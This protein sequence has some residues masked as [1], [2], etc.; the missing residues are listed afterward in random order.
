MVVWEHPVRSWD[1]AS[2]R[3]QRERDV[4]PA[5]PL[6]LGFEGIHIFDITDPT[7]PVVKKQFAWLRRVTSAGAPASAGRPH[8]DRRAGRRARRPLPLHRRLERHL[9]RHRHRPHQALAD[10]TDAKFLSRAAHGRAGVLPRQQL[11]AQRRRHHDRLRDVRRRQRPR[12]VQVRHGQARHRGGHGRGPGGV[13]NPT[14]SVVAVD[15]CVDRPLGLVHLRRQVPVYG[16]EPG[17]GTRPVRG[18]RARVLNRSLFF[19]DPRDG[20]TKGTMVHPR[21]QSTRENCTW[22]NFNV[23]PTYKGYYARLGQL[24]DG[25][26]GVRLTNPAG[27]RDRL[28][29]PG[30]QYTRGTTRRRPPATGRPTATTATSTS[31]TSVAA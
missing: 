18:D 5:R 15:G 4:R 13:E 7:N 21:P 25:H 11:A 10:L 20:E 9:Q 14:L 6:G 3:R 8:G 1:S 26:L 24:R 28:R 12:H 30:A 23:I 29:R 2:S 16:H 31:P 19:L 27:R 22:H 17:G